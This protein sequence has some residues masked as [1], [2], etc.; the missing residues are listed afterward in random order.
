MRMAAYDQILITDCDNKSALSVRSARLVNDA[1][2][3]SFYTLH[4]LYFTIF[5]NI[6][7]KVHQSIPNRQIAISGCHVSLRNMSM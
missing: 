4:E 1:L 6:L 2:Y 3:K 5:F 7:E